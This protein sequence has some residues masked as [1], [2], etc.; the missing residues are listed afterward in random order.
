MRKSQCASISMAAQTT[1]LDAHADNHAIYCFS[2]ISDT[3]KCQQ[4]LTMENPNGK[5]IGNPPADNLGDQA[6]QMSKVTIQQPL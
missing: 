2:P 1:A 6:N 5:D 3:P 4:P